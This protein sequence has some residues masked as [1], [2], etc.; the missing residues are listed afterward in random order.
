M[1]D[2][3]Y[4][5]QGNEIVMQFVAIDDIED[6]QF[7][8]MH[9]LLSHGVAPVVRVIS[10]RN[11]WELLLKFNKKEESHGKESESE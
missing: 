10:T 3:G 5:D 7:M 6:E 2:F 11:G 4:D 8:F 1:S 9:E